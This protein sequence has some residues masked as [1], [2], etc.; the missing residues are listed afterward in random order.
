MVLSV[1]NFTNHFLSWLVTWY[2]NCLELE[3]CSKLI[4]VMHLNKMNPK[5]RGYLAER[6]PLFRV[7]LQ[8]GKS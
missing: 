5:V 8:T 6:P 3:L 7:L 2:N 1:G 4:E